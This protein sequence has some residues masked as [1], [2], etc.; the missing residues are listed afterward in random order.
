ML[1]E[2]ASVR[3]SEHFPLSDL[4]Q[5]WYAVFLDPNLTLPVDVDDVAIFDAVL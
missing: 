3:A 5:I 1:C 2:R 4:N